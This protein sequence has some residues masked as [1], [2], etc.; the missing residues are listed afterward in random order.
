MKHQSTCGER[1]AEF[2]RND[3]MSKGYAAHYIGITVEMLT[4]IELDVCHPDPEAARRIEELTDGRICADDW[5]VEKTSL[6]IDTADIDCSTEDL[7]WS[8]SATTSNRAA[9]RACEEL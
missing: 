2:R 3:G 6:D 5:D 8:C 1:L 4:A 9:L 7:D